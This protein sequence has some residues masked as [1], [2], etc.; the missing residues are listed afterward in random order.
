MLEIIHPDYYK[1]LMELFT[2]IRCQ[3]GLEIGLGWSESTQAFLES[4]PDSAL[5]SIEQEDY[6]GVF[7]PLQ[8]K[9]GNRITIIKG[10]TPEI[11]AKIKMKPVDYIF[12]DAAHDY[13][14][15]KSDIIGTIQLL[16]PDG[17]IAF[18]D[19]GLTGTT[20]EGKEFGVTKAVDELIPTFWPCIF[21]K[22]TIKA[23]R[24]AGE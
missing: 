1:T 3:K 10:R 6:H 14:S 16:K 17:I 20:E 24:R 9:Y 4:F 7:R 2:L 21:N 15:V 12:I 11:Y 22:R 19:Y 23:F 13:E 8:E 18:D 5:V